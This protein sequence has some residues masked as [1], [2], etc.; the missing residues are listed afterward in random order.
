MKIKIT[1]NQLKNLFLIKEQNEECYL[2][3]DFLKGCKE[4]IEKD[5]YRFVSS[6]M[7]GNI[8]LITFNKKI[9]NYNIIIY[10]YDDNYMQLNVTQ[11]KDNS[12]TTFTTDDVELSGT[13]IKISNF[14]LVE[15]E[16][17]I[18]YRKITSWN[19]LNDFLID[20]S[21]KKEG[22]NTNNTLD[23][24]GDI[25]KLEDLLSYNVDDEDFK[26]I[27][28][29]VRK[30]MNNKEDF[31]KL[32]QEYYYEYG[33]KLYEEITDVSISTQSLVRKFHEELGKMGKCNK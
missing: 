18:L 20:S 27:T 1:E 28:T 29:I 10:L 24:E 6:E 8:C 25:E 15:G 32:R 13:S 9:G 2:K 26:Q 12:V 17:N 23:F 4:I 22:S 21:T 30:Y 3:S 7:D 14:R 11:D 19:I 31:C 16:K 33:D 5:G